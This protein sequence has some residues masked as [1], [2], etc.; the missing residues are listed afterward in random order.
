[1]NIIKK[2][3]ADNDRYKSTLE[4]IDGHVF[5]HLDVHKWGAETVKLIRLD[6]KHLED[7]ARSQGYDFLFMY[8][9]FGMKFANMIKPLDIEQEL[10]YGYYLGAWRLDNGN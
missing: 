1:M 8:N 3:Y 9:N 4:F 6:L 7:V 2:I 10:D 5:V